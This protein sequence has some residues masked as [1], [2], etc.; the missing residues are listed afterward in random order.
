MLSLSYSKKFSGYIKNESDHL[1]DIFIA[2][3]QVTGDMYIFKNGIHANLANNFAQK[4]FS[5]SFQFSILKIALKTQN[6][7]A[8]AWRCL[9]KK[10][11]F[12]RKG[13]YVFLVNFCKFFQSSYSIEHFWT[14]T[15]ENAFDDRMYEKNGKTIHLNLTQWLFDD[16]QQ[17]LTKPTWPLIISSGSL[18]IFSI[19]LFQTLWFQ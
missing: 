12:I 6:A 4:T 3:M 19:W 11:N 14:A 16:F 1:D 13:L 17:G 2:L 8:V 10:C 15:P 18:F 7:N 9:V 5:K